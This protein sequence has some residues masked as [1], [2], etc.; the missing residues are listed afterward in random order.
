MFAF[1]K[2]GLDGLL[3]ARPRLFADA[4]GSFVKTFHEG[5]FREA[6]IA[7]TLREEFFSV[8]KQNVIRGMHFQTPPS[9]H[10]KLVYCVTGKILDVVLDIRT[11]SPT[12]GAFRSFELSAENRLLLYI[13]I[14]FAHGFRALTDDACMIYKTD[15]LYDPSRDCGI[16][17]DSFDFDWGAATPV[18][19]ERDA[20]FPA[21]ADYPSP[22]SA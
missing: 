7:F 2:T 14:G 6:G 9:A 15:A 3:L 17:W 13:P 18:V 5:F 21:F 16:R 1:E 4:R 11:S 12:Y 20:A 10:N 8:S 19:S 22:F